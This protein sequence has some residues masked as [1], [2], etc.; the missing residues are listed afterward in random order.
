MNLQPGDFV[1]HKDFGTGR[2]VTVSD[3]DI[4]ID[5]QEY[6]KRRMT[7]ELANRSLRK[8]DPEGFLA[9]LYEEPERI[10]H[11]GYEEK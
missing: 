6:P 1:H 3:Q 2:V 7:H 11:L 8:L 10:R 4:I 9:R 5:F